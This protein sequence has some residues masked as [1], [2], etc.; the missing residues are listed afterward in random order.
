[1][2]GVIPVLSILAKIE[3]RTFRSLLYNVPDRMCAPHSAQETYFVLQEVLM[4]E[5]SKS[6][7]QK[8]RR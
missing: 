3:K 6:S 4:A 7:V 1:M 2:L 5:W 8:V